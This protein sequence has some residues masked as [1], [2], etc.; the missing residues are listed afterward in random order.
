[1]GILSG[2]GQATLVPVVFY[3]KRTLLSG[4]QT[5]VWYC[6]ARISC[7]LPDVFKMAAYGGAKLSVPFSINGDLRHGHQHTPTPAHTVC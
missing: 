2:K 6:P 4:S 3:V 7:K 5:V 1:M